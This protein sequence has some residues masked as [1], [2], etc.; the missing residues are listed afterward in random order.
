M[1][2]PFWD[3]AVASLGERDR[4]MRGL[5][6]RYPGIHMTRRGDAF[7][8]L[9][10]AI[11]G[12]QISVKAAQ[13]IWNRL[14]IATGGGGDAGDAVRGARGAHPRHDAAQG[15]AVRAQGR[16]PA[17]SRPAFR[18][19]P[20]RPGR[21]A[22]AGRRVA[23]RRA[24]RRQGH[25]PLDGRDVPHVPRVARRRPAG[26]RHRPA[27]RD[28]APLFRRRA[29]RS[30]RRFAHTRRAGSPT[31]ASPRGTCGAPSIRSRS[32]IDMAASPPRS[33]APHI[34]PAR[35]RK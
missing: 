34:D 4:V 33:A 26:R 23:D 25:R 7:T 14:V 11:V 28:G 8:T 32:S 15:G 1:K 3:V 9:A 21:L 22:G 30:P 2:P 27:E 31:A 12:Q 6:A 10:R 13:T 19:R 16:L 5:I 17:R 29:A 18:F 24:D 35:G 20:A